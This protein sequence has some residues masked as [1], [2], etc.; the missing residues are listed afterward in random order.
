MEILTTAPTIPPV[1]RI[2][3]LVRLLESNGPPIEI[4]YIPAQWP[5]GKGAF[6]TAW[7]RWKR[8]AEQEA[9]KLRIERKGDMAL[10]VTTW[11]EPND[12]PRESDGATG[13]Y[14][15]YRVAAG[16]TSPTQ[17]TLRAS[18][19]DVPVTTQNAAVQRAVRLEQEARAQKGRP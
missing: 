2:K 4:P 11:R 8:A 17:T 10:I 19:I 15:L 9:A 13:G 1:V 18:T 14:R 6:Y 7:Q 3:Q 16:T 5:K 12:M